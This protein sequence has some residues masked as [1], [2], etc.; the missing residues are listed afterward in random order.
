[1]LLEKTLEVSPIHHLE[2]AAFIRERSGKLLRDE[3]PQLSDV[4]L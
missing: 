1:M 4:A 2:V 3:A